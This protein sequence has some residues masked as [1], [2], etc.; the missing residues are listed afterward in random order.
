MKCFSMFTGIGGFDLALQNLGHEIVGACEIDKYARSVFEKHFKGVPI[1]NDATHLHEESLP[2]FD[3]LSGGFPC[4]AFSIAGKRRG[5]DDTRGSLFFE[6]A[7]LA[8]EKRPSYLLLENVKGLLSHDKGQTFRTIIS[9][10]DEVGYDVEWQLL[11]S[12]Y[13]VP[14]NRERIFIVGHLRGQRARQVFPLGDFN[15]E[16]DRKIKKAG[17]LTNHN[18]SSFY[19]TSGVSP[20]LI[21]SEGS[22]SIVKI[23]HH[24]NS[25]SQA[26]RVYDTSGIGPTLGIGNAMSKPLIGVKDDVTCIGGLQDNA[27]VMK[28]QSPSLTQAMGNGGGHIPI[29]VK[30]GVINDK[31]T[32]K[33]VDKSTCIDANY[34]KG[35]D[36]H[37]QRTMVTIPVVSPDRLNKSQNGRRFKT[38]GE[39][40]FTLTVQDRHGVYDGMKIRKL[41]PLEC[42]RLQGFPDNWTKYDDDGNIVS[43]T[44]RY[45]MCGNAVTVSVIE[46][47]A[48]H[49]DFPS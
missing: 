23:K 38:D 33:E 49:F 14:Q 2:Y 10:L 27:A 35:M 6:I 19:D 34:H 20:T 46:Y 41:T 31:G 13:H 36:N 21:S 16:T 26:D 29:I 39:E 48:S 18:G 7:R 40:A 25:D 5:F 9:T 12:K 45:K 30:K 44:Q 28:N 8:K 11:N 17:Q 3:L 47:I 37:G 24:V 4:Q 32:F 43:D 1:Y 22:G 15:E 42:E